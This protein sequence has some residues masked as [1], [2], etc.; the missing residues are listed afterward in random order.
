MHSN[1]NGVII[2]TPVVNRLY[3]SQVSL[4]ISVLLV[5]SPSLPLEGQ[6]LVNSNENAEIFMTLDLLVS[7]SK[8]N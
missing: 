2:N 7:S 1:G 3:V 4:L 8:L 6:G 5:I